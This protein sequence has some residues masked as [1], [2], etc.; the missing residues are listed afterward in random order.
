M[1]ISLEALRCLDAIDRHGSFAAAAAALHRVPSA[2]SHA[3]GNLESALGVPIFVRVGRRAVLTEAG[4]ALL[5][6]G[7]HLLAAAEALERRVRR[8]SS[9]WE[10]ELR[11][12]VDALI[13]VSRLMPLLQAFQAE[14]QVTAIR[15]GVEVLGGGWDAI[16]T[17]RADLAIGAP[18]EPPVHGGLTMAPLGEVRLVFA[19]A[20]DH[21]LASV[22]EPISAR[23]RALHR[24]VVVADTSRQLAARTSGLL[25]GQS[26]LY[27][28]D[29]E[30]KAAA[31]VAGLGVGHLPR[32]LAER[33][34][35]AGRLVIR[36]LE[37]T[38][39]PTRLN[40]AWRARHKGKALAWFVA[41]LAEPATQARLLAG[42]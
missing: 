29:M 27:V 9:G 36:C 21:P 20:P 14:C 33:E 39:P 2:L 3:I 26:A 35:A 10:Q 17:Q 25:E 28:P 30:S 4:Q 18:G 24:A 16:A 22:P 40:V 37:E 12:A 34:V 11:I 31:Q 7:R 6:D 8:V 41:A 23:V 42:L 19:V 32:W 13:P 5:E 38:R 1:N 15:I